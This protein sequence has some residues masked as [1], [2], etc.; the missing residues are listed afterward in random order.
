MY[1]ILIPYILFCFL[2][3]CLTGQVE[4][5]S[6]KIKGGNLSYRIWGDGEPVVFLN[7]GPGF[8]SDG[9]ENYAIEL[10]KYRRVILFDQRGTG[11]SKNKYC[12]QFYITEMTKDL[13]KLREHLGF[14][15][16]DVFGHSFGGTYAQYYIAQF[17]KS[18]NKVI[19][20][21]SPCSIIAQG[22]YQK[23][24][25][26]KPENR[27]PLENTIAA[28]YYE[29]LEKK[30]HRDSLK[31]IYNANWSRYYVSKAENYSKVAYWFLNSSNPS[32]VNIEF[33][34]RRKKLEKR[35]KEFT[36]PVLIIHGLND[37]INIANPL[38]LHEFFPNSELKIIEDSGHIMS[39]DNP[40]EYFK[41]I[42][43]FLEK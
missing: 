26:I 41:A 9:Y 2:S 27:T 24:K 10:A 14:E 8:A 38:R 3:T 11:K 21:A 37:F 20:S 42:R 22:K 28:A 19:L 30:I 1:R 33:N 13:E 34:F 40:Q 12:C 31:K 15:K 7:G 17:P 36:R 32:S 35:L 25:D 23:F 18:I 16:W 29:G 6:V 43:E 4:S 39:I 5:G